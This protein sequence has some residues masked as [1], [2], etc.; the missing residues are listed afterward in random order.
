LQRADAR[1]A[2]PGKGQ[3]SGAP[4][5]DQL[6]IDHVGRHP[7]Q[8]QIASPL[9]NDLVPG[10]MRNQVGKPLQRH[11]IPIKDILG[12]CLTQRTNLSHDAT[13]QKLDQTGRIV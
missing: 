2:A 1:I 7:N 12:N 6:V 5:P 3:A 9:T 4:H 10:G 11:R 13:L 8:V